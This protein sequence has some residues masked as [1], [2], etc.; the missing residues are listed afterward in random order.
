VRRESGN[1]WSVCVRRDDR[2][3]IHISSASLGLKAIVAGE[4]DERSIGGFF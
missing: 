3:A 4:V 1:E 2:V